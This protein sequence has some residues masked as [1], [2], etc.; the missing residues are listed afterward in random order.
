MRLALIIYGALETLSG[1][2]EYDRQLVA[3]LRQAGHT[4]EIISLPWRT[5]AHHLTD[6]ASAEWTRRLQNTRCDILLQDEL[7]HPSLAWVNRRLPAALPIV[8]IVHH[9]RSSERHPPLLRVLYRWVERAYLRTMRGFIFN[10][11]TTRAVVEGMLGSVT[12]GVV[13]WPAG[14]RFSPLPTLAEI[15]ARAQ[16]PGPLRIIFVGNVT[17]RKGLHTLLAGL[18]LCASGA[19]QLTI[20]GQTDVEPEYVRQVQHQIM[21]Q[22]LAA[23]VVW[24]RRLSDD[25]LRAELAQSD[26]LAVP[27][28]YEGFGIVYLEGFGFG[29]PAIA[30]TA[31]AASEIITPGQTGWLIP[32]DDPAAIASAL[33]PLLE[34]RT[35]LPTLSLAARRHY[36]QHPTWQ[37]SM[38]RARHFLEHWA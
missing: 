5:Y 33:H 36:D 13:A 37:A 7:N 4:V 34:D 38:E 10:S 28:A 3:C 2:Y 15:I 17:E 24:R 27:S 32:P 35:R 1:G 9:C 30:T 18:A 8:S 19:W 6:N 14:D 31:G 23:R 16:R 25:A 12:R 20:V 26:V 22:N 29:L 21:R 11:H